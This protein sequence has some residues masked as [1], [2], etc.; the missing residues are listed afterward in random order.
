[1]PTPR[2]RL[3]DITPAPAHTHAGSA[4]AAPESPARRPTYIGG[5]PVRRPERLC[6][7]V[8]DSPLA[9]VVRTKLPLSFTLPL[10]MFSSV[11]K[12]HRVA[13]PVHVSHGLEDKVVPA[14][15][16]ERLLERLTL[17]AAMRYPATWLPSK[18]HNDMPKFWIYQTGKV[19]APA[20]RAR[21]EALN[22]ETRAYLLG[23][24]KFLSFCDGSSL[25]YS[26]CETEVED[27]S[28]TAETEFTKTDAC[29]EHP[30][31]L[32]DDDDDEDEDG[33]HRGPR[34]ALREEDEEDDGLL[35]LP[36][37]DG[38]VLVV[39]ASHAHAAPASSPRDVLLSDQVPAAARSS[40]AASSVG[41]A[42]G[43]G[44]GAGAGAGGDRLLRR[45][46]S[47][48]PCVSGGGPECSDAVLGSAAD[49]E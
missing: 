6:G 5:Q 32:A 35:S 47:A 2:P 16:A 18:G 21:L 38:P 13:V 46:G 23:F 15:H 49:R 30:G 14:W 26:D 24:R 34:E 44:A 12:V 45:A 9:S 3:S 27:S 41:V 1:M 17:P 39:A 11:D 37:D 42:V 7:V 28:D 29:S 25:Y 36:P 43:V 31:A 20:E 10:D 4:P 33:V 8:L 40:S 19:R 48:E 22:E